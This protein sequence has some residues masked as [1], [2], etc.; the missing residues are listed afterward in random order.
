MMLLVTHYEDGSTLVNTD[1][2]VKIVPVTGQRWNSAIQLN[3]PDPSEGQWLRCRETVDQL[4]K[5]L[6]GLAS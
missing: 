1:N 6:L 2:I 4:N 5:R 3:K